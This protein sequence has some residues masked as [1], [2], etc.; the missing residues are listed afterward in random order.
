LLFYSLFRLIS[1]TSS[2]EEDFRRWDDYDDVRART[3]GNYSVPTIAIP[4]S[5][6]TAGTPAANKR[7]RLPARK[8]GSLKKRTGTTSAA[9]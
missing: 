5:S 6:G 7:A 1:G 9:W 8:N 3:A 2:P 4:T